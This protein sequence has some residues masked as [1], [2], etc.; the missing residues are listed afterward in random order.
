MNDK[1]ITSDAVW[2]QLAPILGFDHRERPVAKVTIVLE[3]G[4][5]VRIYFE[6]LGSEGFAQQLGKVGLGAAEMI[7][8]PPPITMRP[9][10]LRAIAQ[11]IRDELIKVGKRGDGNIFGGHG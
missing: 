1:L 11:A 4:Q 5:P 8:G 9:S 7:E 2:D 3:A 10:D 6:A